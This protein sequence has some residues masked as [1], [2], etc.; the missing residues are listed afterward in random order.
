[1]SNAAS[2]PSRS[3]RSSTLGPP[4]GPGAASRRLIARLRNFSL[5]EEALQEAMISAMAHWSRNGIPDKPQNWLLQVAHRKAIDQLRQRG[6]QARIGDELAVLAIDEA[7]EEEPTPIPDERLRLIFTCCHPAIEPKSQIALTLRTLGVCR[8]PRSPGPSS[9]R[10]R[11]WASASPA[12]RRRSRRRAFPSR[13]R[14]RPSGPPASMPS[15]PSSTSSSMRVT[16]RGPWRDAISPEEAIWLG[17]LLDGSPRRSRDRRLPR[18]HA[19][20]H[21][22]RARAS[23]RMA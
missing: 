1:M 3:A 11:Q 21:A 10:R 12:P 20:T 13:C 14:S 4:R 2:M 18:A 17:R 15:S 6:S 23:T 5:A 22:R 16:R 8:P 19:L 7:H 9:T